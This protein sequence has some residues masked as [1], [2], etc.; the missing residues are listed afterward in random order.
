[1]IVNSQGRQPSLLKLSMLADKM[2]CFVEFF[3]DSFCPTRGSR[4]R[5]DINVPRGS[6]RRRGSIAPEMRE[7]RG[8]RFLFQ[9]DDP[10]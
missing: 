7:N 9:L 3:K 6:K 10:T 2:P 1:M 8:F 4:L 5:E